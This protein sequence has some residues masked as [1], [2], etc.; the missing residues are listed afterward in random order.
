[1]PRNDGTGPLGLGPRTGRGRGWCRGFFFTGTRGGRRRLGVFGMIVP[2][3]GVIIRDVMNPQGLLHSLRRKYLPL[4]KDR[5][6]E[7]IDAEYTIV[8]PE[9]ESAGDTRY[10]PHGGT[11]E[12]DR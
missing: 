12:I 9:N 10:P 1:M 3:V 11:R 2:I 4:N 7:P 8:E 6:Q 5:R